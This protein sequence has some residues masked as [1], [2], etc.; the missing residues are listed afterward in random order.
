MVMGFEAHQPYRIRRDFME[1]LI[2]RA[3]ESGWHGAGWHEGVGDLWSLIF[4]H[5]LDREVLARVSLRSY[6][7]ATRILVET[8]R[9][10]RE[11]GARPVFTL[12][13]SGV[14][15]EQLR[16]WD[17]EV[18]GLLKQLWDLEALEPVAE[19]YFHSLVSL[20]ADKEE[21][22]DQLRMSSEA[23]EEIFGSRPR[24]S[25]NT[26]MIFDDSIACL[27]SRAGFEGTI[28]EGV[29]RILGWRSPNH[30]Y[31][32]RGCGVK[33]LLRNYRLS[34]D[35]GFRFANRGWDQYP[36]TADKYSEWVRAS[37]GDL[38]TIYIDYETFGEH[39]REETGILEF[40]RHLPLEL[41]TRGVEILGPSEAFR[42]FKPV[43]IYSVPPGNT[44]SWA[45]VEKDLTAWKSNRAQEL[46][47]K[48]H[49]ALEPLARR[50]GGPLLRIWRA[51]GIS[52]H[53]YY[54][55]SKT[56]PSGDVHKYFSPYGDVA[57]AFAS[58]V[59]SL[60]IL[61]IQLLPGSF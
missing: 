52:D 41:F 32:S 22:V 26:E 14:L 21:F 46:A 7:P 54:M 53:Y 39:F 28:T 38:V 10:L 51:L 12:S 49:E 17:P 29:E 15:I 5:E 31:E 61:A 33:I 9:L 58:L 27:I 24:V 6:R 48:A 45:D 1:R 13:M 18:L 16:I 3:G 40:L 8:A 47:L 35:I 37:P 43:G 25:I 11:R 2:A 23:L 59:Q 50:A 34:D 30:V 36:L 20:Y 56:G 42:R 19:P 60:T 44:I 57:E 4:D 55:A